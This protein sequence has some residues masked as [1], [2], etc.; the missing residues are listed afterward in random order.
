MR[1]IDASDATK[2]SPCATLRALR[3]M[4]RARRATYPARFARHVPRASRDGSY[5][6]DA[7]PFDRFDAH[8]SCVIRTHALD[9]I[10]TLFFEATTSPTA[11]RRTEK[12]SKR[13]GETARSRKERS[14]DRRLGEKGSITRASFSAPPA[15]PGPRSSAATTPRTNIAAPRTCRGG[16]DAGARAMRLVAPCAIPAPASPWPAA[17]TARRDTGS[18]PAVTPHFTCSRGRRAPLS[19]RHATTGTRSVNR[20]RKDLTE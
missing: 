5:G 8:A 12:R 2:P 11:T 9:A 15:G 4:S 13:H 6:S 18:A 3:I 1:R 14:M 17:S 19:R 20:Y 10:R 16:R 7:K